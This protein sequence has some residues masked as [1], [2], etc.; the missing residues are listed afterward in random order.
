MS[1]H[2]ITIQM[3]SKKYDILINQSFHFGFHKSIN[4]GLKQY[5]FSI[6][7][8]FHL[9]R[10]PLAFSNRKLSNC[11]I[12][13]TTASKMAK[14][15]TKVLPILPIIQNPSH[16]PSNG[17]IERF[18]SS[19]SSRSNNTEALKLPSLKSPKISKREQLIK[20]SKLTFLQIWINL[21]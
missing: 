3:V 19:T 8:D 21:S 15:N 5:T 7:I 6:L 2:G 4:T 18:L 12:S 17:S 20:L 16:Q 10:E 1:T 13:K 14:L 11:P 9:V